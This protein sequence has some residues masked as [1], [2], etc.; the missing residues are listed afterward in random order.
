M[1]S[2][3]YMTRALRARDPRFAHILGRLG[4]ETTAMTAD[5]GPVAVS[6]DMKKDELI[7]IAEA[8]GV[9]TD[10]GDTKAEII[11]K[12]ESARKE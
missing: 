10:G 3:S 12:I 1:K 9:E 8:E 6:M 5:D 11:R 7:R 2:Q 4:Y